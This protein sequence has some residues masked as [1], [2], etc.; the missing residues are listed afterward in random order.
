MNFPSTI[1]E[2]LV[3]TG[4]LEGGALHF[5]L[6]TIES[7]STISPEKHV[8]SFLMGTPGAGGSTSS[9]TISFEYFITCAMSPIPQKH[10]ILHFR[11]FRLFLS[12]EKNC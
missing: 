4:A 10:V 8:P 6:Y 7:I 5:V 12:R 1:Q 9:I 11:Q 3:F 2:V